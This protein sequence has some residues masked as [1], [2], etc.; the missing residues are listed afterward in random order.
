M[1]AKILAFLG[2]ILHG[3]LP[4]PNWG[5]IAA[6]AGCAVAAFLVLAFVVPALLSVK[7]V[8][9]AG[10]IVVG[11]LVYTKVTAAELEALIKKV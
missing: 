10:G 6:S 8:A 11:Y 4:N 9:L 5:K 2:N 7:V 1:F 3:I